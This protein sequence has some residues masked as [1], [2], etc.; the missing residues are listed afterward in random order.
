[1]QKKIIIKEYTSS[2][3][4]H[5]IMDTGHSVVR[6]VVFLFT[7]SF[8]DSGMLHIIIDMMAVFFLSVNT[9]S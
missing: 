1:M 4:I 5:L 3:L 2:T 8:G 7:F 6:T 9:C